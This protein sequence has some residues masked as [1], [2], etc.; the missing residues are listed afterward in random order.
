M[1][2]VHY[3]FLSLL[4]IFI[5][6]TSGAIAGEN[7]VSVS[8]KLIVGAERIPVVG[9]KVSAWPLSS[10]GL[11]DDASITSVP[12]GEDGQYEIELAPGSYYFI[13]ANEKYYSYYG[14]NPVTV[15]VSGLEGMNL[16]LVERNPALPSVE[17]QIKTGII[18]QLTYG[19]EP[20]EGAIVTIY[21]DLN[22]QLKGMGLRMTMPTNSAGIFEL[23][24]PAGTY[25][26]VARKRQSG[27]IRGPLKAG[28]YFGYYSGNPLLIREGGLAKVSFAMI[29]VPEE[30]AQLGDR[31]FGQTSISGT[32]VDEKGQPVAGVWVLLYAERVMLNRPLYVSQLTD[33]KGRYVVSFPSGGVY[34]L[35]ARN[36]LGGPPEPGELYGRY[37]GNPDGSVS[38][39][40]GKYLEDIQLVVEP[41]E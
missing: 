41:I 10:M 33:D 16:S 25:Y 39:S 38:L 18:G 40:T 30:V 1:S 31:M 3:F 26:L 37:L 20:L 23:E 4:M 22:S 24:M 35:A 6:Q 12:T 7:L 29:E 32:V 8:G 27:H 13:A 19:G 34:W 11:A 28:D 9:A 36:H 5:L 14:R 15:P 2:R 21:S 17:P